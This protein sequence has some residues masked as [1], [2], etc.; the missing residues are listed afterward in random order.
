[1]IGIVRINCMMC[2]TRF[3]SDEDAEGHRSVCQPR[4][5]Y[6]WPRANPYWF[7]AVAA[8]VGLFVGSLLPGLWW[9]P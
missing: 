2:G 1:M 7:A 4:W 8:A 5:W 3:D 6:W 9:S